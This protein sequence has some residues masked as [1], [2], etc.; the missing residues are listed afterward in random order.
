MITLIGDMHFTRQ[1]YSCNAYQLRQK[2]WNHKGVNHKG[3]KPHCPWLYLPYRWSIYCWSVVS[4]TRTTEP[5][6]KTHASQWAHQPST[7]PRL[8]AP[9][10]PT[11]P[12]VSPSQ[13]SIPLFPRAGNRPS[14]PRERFTSSTTLTSV[15][16]GTTLEDVSMHMHV[17]ACFPFPLS[18]PW[19]GWKSPILGKFFDVRHFWGY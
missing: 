11:S 17:H 3:F 6:G 15:R 8:S 2:G 14:L 9:L 13:T 18:I 1:S 19:L 7:S 16:V 5:H 10:N 4:V 12:P